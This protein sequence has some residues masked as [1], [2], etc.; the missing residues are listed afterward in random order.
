MVSTRWSGTEAPRGDDYDA[1]WQRLAAQ[2]ADIHGEAN[3]VE[4][5]LR[6]HGL[7]RV[8]DA[9]CG[10]GRVAIELAR[11]GFDVTGMDA[12]AQ[13]LDTARANAPKLTWWH[14]DLADPVAEFGAPFDLAVLAGNVMIFLTPGTE[15]RVLE[16]VAAALSPG[17]LVVAGFSVRPDRLALDE[18]DRLAAA[19]GLCLQDRWST[20]DR[21]PYNGGDYAVTV[22]R[23]AAEGV[24]LPS[25]P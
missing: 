8:L 3:L 18:Y 5:L 22:H 12:D 24:R 7:H 2:G 9:G 20:W 4:S 17:G 14:V 19:A 25:T 16:H 10:T 23:I 15:G 6:D 13:M 21:A 1:R 11:R